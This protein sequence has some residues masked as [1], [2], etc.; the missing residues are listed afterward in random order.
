MATGEL[1][2]LAMDWS[3]MAAAGEAAAAVRTH[4]ARH[5]RA[6]RTGKAYRSRLMAV[7]LPFWRRAAIVADRRSGLPP[8]GAVHWLGAPTV[9]PEPRPAGRSRCAGGGRGARLRRSRRR[10]GPERAALR[11]PG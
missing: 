9:R 3:C 11:D 6:R 1:R 8:A 10:P 2:P 4:A 7:R 5:G